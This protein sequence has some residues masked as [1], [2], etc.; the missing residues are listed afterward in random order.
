MYN[1]TK[2]HALTRS[3]LCCIKSH[4][5]DANITFK[6]VLKK[7]LFQHLKFPDFNLHKFFIHV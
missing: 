1:N 7:S 2:S 6:K 5:C 3:S 4:L